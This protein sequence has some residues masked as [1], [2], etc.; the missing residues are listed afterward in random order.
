MLRC[1]Y[2]GSIRCSGNCDGKKLNNINIK[3]DYKW[4]S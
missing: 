2:C 1:P 4:K 3:K